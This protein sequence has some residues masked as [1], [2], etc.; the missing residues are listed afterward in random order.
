M[1]SILSDLRV[2]VR[3]LVRK[4]GFTLVVIATLALG[5]G[6]NTAIFSVVHGVLLAPLPYPEP[7]RLVHL[8]NRWE[9]VPQGD[10]SPAE[11]VDYRDELDSFSSFGAYA[12]GEVTLAEP[13]GEAVRLPAAAV[14]A[15]LL[16]ML[17]PRLILGRHFTHEEELPDRGNVVILS[18]GLW[19]RRFG[20]TDGVLGRRVEIDGAA[21]TVVGVA[22]SALRLP[23]DFADAEPTALYVPLELGG[24]DRSKRGSHYLHGVGRLAPGTSL[25]R[26]REEVDR[27]AAGFVEAHPDDYPPGMRFASYLVPLAQDVVGPAQPALA[28]LLGAVLLLLL[29]ACIN[30]AN[31]TLARLRE[32]RR[33]LAVH[34]ALGAGRTR[35]LR[36]V[37]AESLLLAVAGGVTGVLLAA[38][39][40]EVLPGLLPAGL[41]RLS[42]VRLDLPVLLFAAAATVGSACIF[43]LAP[44]WRWASQAPGDALLGGGGR[45]SEDREGRRF[46]GALVVA[47]VALA[48][49][50]LAGAGLLTRSFLH[51]LGV[52]PG[53]TTRGVAT[54]DV[55]LPSQEYAETPRVTGFYARLLDEVRA[56]PGVESAGAVAGL[57]LTGGGGDLNIR[58]EGKPDL[59]GGENRDAD[60]RVVTPGYF[61]ALDM[62]ILRGRGLTAADDE[63]A[64]GAVVINETL[65]R[66][67]WPGENPL[68]ARFELGGGAGPGWVTVVGVVGD[69]RRR[70]LDQDDPVRQ[71]YLP[72]AQFRFWGSGDPAYSLSLVVRSERTPSDL[73]PELRRAV[74]GLDPKL[75]LEQ[76]RS[77]DEIRHASVATP[78]FLLLLVVA[79]SVL[80][81]ALAAVGLYGVL[82]YAVSRRRREIGIRMALG[83]RAGE[84][85]GLVLRQGFLLTALG[86]VLGLGGAIAVSRLLTNLLYATSPT[87]VATLSVVSLILLGITGIACFVPARRAART[88]PAVVLKEG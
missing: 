46:T 39:I 57:P 26:A 29:V 67:Y 61:E 47:Q 27:V 72:H 6:A 62:T 14:S 84:V 31:L 65:A 3:S 44:A 17:G 54:L 52:D 24:V 21:A 83:A 19:Q 32:R 41:P 20:G 58:I 37:L 22:E 9:E 76:V 60:W 55:H 59:P 73:A 51:L 7:D 79:F 63:D 5:L 11:L 42:Q 48:L 30:V 28:V 15:E 56:L 34:T 36:L 68:G 50:L 77:L 40:T 64:P 74:H 88:D 10:L 53:F 43:G 87:D 25:E 86:L 45:A 16:P 71:M 33:E 2:A 81:V 80:A 4:P 70:G 75:P 1:S 66:Q 18:H 85:S 82:A 13:G 49:V 35:L 23:S 8:H 12:T 38:W 78:R 69:V